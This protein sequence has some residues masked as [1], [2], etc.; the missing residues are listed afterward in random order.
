M[1]D[2]QEQQTRVTVRTARSS[3]LVI[4]PFDSSEREEP[5]GEQHG[6]NRRGRSDNLAPNTPEPHPDRTPASPTGG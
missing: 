1:L 3:T 5:T 4:L 2:W 6:E